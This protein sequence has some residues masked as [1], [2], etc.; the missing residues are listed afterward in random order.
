MSPSQPVGD[1]R[2]THAG[3]I[4]LRNVD[5]DVE[6]LVVRPSRPDPS[7]SA[8]SATW[9]LPKGHIEP[10][11]TP[12][13]AAQREARE[14]AG[15]LCSELTFAGSTSYVARGE[16]VRCAFFAAQLDA[17]EEPEE[18]RDRAWLTLLD[19][20][21]AMPFEETIRIVREIALHA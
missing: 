17:L 4:V 6:V 12:V 9:V 2:W 5:T 18:P 1:D 15:A 14:E 7:Q 16:V 8:D 21:R 10:G 13:M 11:E 3:C 19:L 20:E